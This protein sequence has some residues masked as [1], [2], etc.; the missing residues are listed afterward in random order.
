M[1]IAPASDPRGAWWGPL[2]VVAAVVAFTWFFS[3]QGIYMHWRFETR[4]YDLANYEL[5]FWNTIHGRPFRCTYLENDSFL[6]NHFSPALLLP[7]AAYAL[8]PRAETI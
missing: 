7:N 3:V 4:A 6:S 5:V 1:R 2:V 8:V